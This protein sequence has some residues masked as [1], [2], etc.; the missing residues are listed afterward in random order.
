MMPWGRMNPRQAQAM[1]RR[2]GMAMEPVEGVEEVVIRTRDQEQV[3][4]NPEVTILTVQGTRTYQVVGASES[5]AR[6]GSTPSE[7]PGAPP[8][9]TGAG[10]AEEDVELV[11][12]QTGTDR[13]TALEALGEAGGAPAEAI[14]AL[15]ARRDSARN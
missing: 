15:L 4:R 10:P 5:R 2:M 9:P 11:M 12:A 13:A 3:F 7:V 14:L 6:T 8:A 1:M